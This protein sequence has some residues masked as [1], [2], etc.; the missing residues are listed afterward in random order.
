MQTL[1]FC[2]E[3]R[4]LA[5]KAAPTALDPPADGEEF[6]P[7]AFKW[8]SE[9]EA[10]LCAVIYNSQRTGPGCDCWLGALCSLT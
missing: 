7:P 4:F 2:V 1:R 5:L 6:E 9:C 3:A 10:A 8:N